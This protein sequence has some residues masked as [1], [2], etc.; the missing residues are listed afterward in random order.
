M[1]TIL[2]MK[3]LCRFVPT[4]G[5]F[6]TQFCITTHKEVHSVNGMPTYVSEQRLL[7]DWRRRKRRGN[8]I[9][10]SLK[11]SSKQYKRFRRGPSET[12]VGSTVSP[13]NAFAA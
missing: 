1:T 9:K 3:G 10:A 11:S 8:G 2:W 5:S 12:L 13:R 4:V 6:P 7:K